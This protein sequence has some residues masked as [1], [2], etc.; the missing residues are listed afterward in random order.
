ME[1]PELRD[2]LARH[3]DLDQLAAAA[4]V[5]KSWNASF[6][7]YLYQHIEWTDVHAENP[8]KKSLEKNAQYVREVTVYRSP[9]TL[10][11]EDF[12]Q[13]E[14]LHLHFFVHNSYSWMRLSKLFVSPS[15]IREVSVCMDMAEFSTV[16]VDCLLTCPSIRILSI[17]FGKF[18]AKSTMLLLDACL[19]LEKLSINGDDLTE[20]SSMDRWEIFP[21]MRSLHLSINSGMSMRHQLEWIR[22]CPLLES[23]SWYIQSSDPFP[24]SE[25]CEI[26]STICRDIKELSLEEGRIP[27]GDIARILD[28]CGDLT[29]LSFF[30]SGFG[31]HAFQ[32]CRRQF[33]ILTRFEVMRCENTTSA[34]SQTI[35]TSCPNLVYFRAN[36]VNARDILGITESTEP[37]GEETGGTSTQ[38]EDTTAVKVDFHPQDWVCLKLETLSL[39]ICGL[40]GKPVEWQR[41]VLRQLSRLKRL[42]NLAIG[43]YEFAMVGSRDGIDLRLE[44]GLDI[45]GS[46]NLLDRFCFDGLHQEMGEEDVLW[47]TKA[48][49]RLERVEG[50]VHYSRK[51]MLE[52]QEILRKEDIAL[53]QYMD[54]LEED[55]LV[56]FEAGP[57]IDTLLL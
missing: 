53:V 31:P 24:T 5:C 41:E 1:L 54:E 22:K 44:S 15:V 23:L 57:D 42:D 38:S 11:L 9:G 14:V 8:S 55:E 47:M 32:A 13:L 20:Q 56:E 18:N 30:D 39:F 45:L 35:L 40:E 48:W 26:L 43:P 27:D 37:T 33:E 16:F 25:M 6:T 2:H 7:P 10:P 17:S 4:A 19:R 29:T 34:M 46:L 50:K 3:L 49:P 36:F 51:R 12:K 52:L 28:R 21:A